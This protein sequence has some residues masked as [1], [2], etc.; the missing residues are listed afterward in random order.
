M[1]FSASAPLLL[2]QEISGK[3]IHHESLPRIGSDRGRRRAIEDFSGAEPRFLTAAEK[4]GIQ[5]P[6]T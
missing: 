6:D 3:G 4:Y 5:G 1:S 2:S